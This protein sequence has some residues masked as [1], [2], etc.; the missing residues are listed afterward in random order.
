MDIFNL[1]HYFFEFDYIKYILLFLIINWFLQKY[2]TN[3][4][5]LNTLLRLLIVGGIIYFIFIVEYK[6]KKDLGKNIE[7]NIDLIH[8][9]NLS[10]IYEDVDGILLYSHILEYRDLNKYSF[11]E[12]IKHYDNFMKIK[13]TILSGVSHPKNYYEILEDE[14]NKCINALSSIMVGNKDNYY[15]NKK[16]GKNIN[17]LKSSNKLRNYIKK[18]YNVFQLHLNDVHQFLKKEWNE[19]KE[20]NINSFKLH[21]SNVKPNMTNTKEYSEHYSLF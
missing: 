16:E 8:A 19:S 7:N 9:P 6:K 11:N 15:Y 18:L 2:F 12:S 5:T 4:I 17:N 3:L 21:L 1:K 14:M 20:K 10:A 13:K